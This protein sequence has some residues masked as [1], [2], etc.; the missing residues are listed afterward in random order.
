MDIDR[1][2]N[3]GG[4]SEAIHRVSFVLDQ[5]EKANGFKDKMDWGT[6]IVTRCTFEEVIGALVSAEQELLTLEGELN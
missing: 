5:L 3:Q 2:K 6:D 1:K 4:L